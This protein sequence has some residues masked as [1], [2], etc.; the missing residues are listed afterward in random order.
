[1]TFLRR[2]YDVFVPAGY[3][4]EI[5]NRSF[6]KKHWSKRRLQVCWNNRVKFV[7][8]SLGLQVCVLNITKIN[9]LKKN[10]LLIKED[11]GWLERANFAERSF[12]IPFISFCCKSCF[13]GFPWGLSVLYIF[14]YFHGFWTD[15][16]S[17][18][19]QTFKMEL[20]TKVI[21]EWKLLTI[22]EKKIMLDVWQGSEYL[23]AEC[24]VNCLAK[25]CYI[26]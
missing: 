17:E 16:Y 20:F 4:F 10:R 25:F 7:K 1:M 2:L 22:L 21:N 15:A 18:P 14:V 13:K 12:L 23:S 6:L 24:K 8:I 9:I 19:C 11:A 26:L 5:F 3:I